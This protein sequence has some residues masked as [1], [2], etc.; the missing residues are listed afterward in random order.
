MQASS[1]GPRISG[2]VATAVYIFQ[3]LYGQAPSYPQ[4]LTYTTQAANGPTF[5]ASLVSS[6][7]QTSDANLALLLLNNLGITASSVP[8][9]N[10]Q[11]QSEY[12]ILLDALKQLLAY[13][14]PAW[15][16]QI[17]YNS[18]NLLAGLESD[19]T[20]GGV[21]ITFNNQ[22][23]ANYSYST[24]A[25][26]TSPTA[27]PVATANAGSSRSVLTSASVTLDASASSAAPGKTLS[28]SWTLTSKPAGSSAVLAN[29]STASASLLPDL[30]G[31]YVASLVVNDGTVTSS[32][33]SV[34]LASAYVPDTGVTA[35]Q[36]Y[37]SGSDTLV[38]CT[39]AGAVAL[40]SA[41]D[42]MIGRD[43][44]SASASDGKLGFSFAAV[45]S[46]AST[47]CI[48]D[49]LTGLYWEGKPTSGVRA[50][51]NTY[52]NAGDSSTGDASSYVTTV[53]A[54]ALCG[55]SD[56]RLPTRDELQGLVDYA[57]VNPSA[58]LDTTWFPNTM[59][60]WYWSA[61]PYLGSGAKAWYV[62]FANGFVS[63]SARSGKLP[64]RLVR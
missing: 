46:Y 9:V 22:A 8:A 4:L 47:E 7:A 45:G 33:A 62:S 43:V 42:G 28:Y 39:S 64:V 60:G 52:S 13:Y 6:Y 35:S 41:Q 59:V 27:I 53:N 2:N 57:L 31:T 23:L 1:N 29:A 17:I 19:A 24:N 5:A 18:V 48:K 55:F 50:Y 61:T 30:V 12:A 40:N 20:Y 36:C 3:A 21:A 26:S 49:N 15:R 38:S 58:T 51:T 14:G 16:G 56:W 54:A 44:S 37:G 11:G 34:R 25:T 63:S 10:A 32:P